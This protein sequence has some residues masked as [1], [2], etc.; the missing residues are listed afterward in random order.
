MNLDKYNDVGLSADIVKELLKAL[1]AAHRFI[2]IDDFERKILSYIVLKEPITLYRVAVDLDLN[3][4]TVYKKAY[5]LSDYG[6]IREVKLKSHGSHY[7]S[8]VK[9]LISCLINDCGLDMNLILSKIRG[10]WGLT[11]LGND[12]VLAFLF[13][14]V[15][16]FSIE[17]IINLS[18]LNKPNVLALMIYDY[19]GS[20]LR[21][22]L[23]SH[24]IDG[25]IASKAGEVFAYYLVKFF[26]SVVGSSGHFIKGERFYAVLDS[27]G[28][29]IAALCN[30]CD[31]NRYCT[32]EVACPRLYEAV[33]TYR[34]QSLKGI[35]NDP[36][37]L[38]LGL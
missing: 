12:S 21:R 9:G 6:L 1:H 5:T 11:M 29:I 28:Y 10:K 14:V 35:N 37:P 4:S 13:V 22:C 18:L 30:L 24:G 23:L 20:D 15:R 16:L 17:D 31:L 19:C 3:F 33:K 25:A 34:R 32:G 8:T 38:R 27:K 2:R 7:E 26:S 36:H